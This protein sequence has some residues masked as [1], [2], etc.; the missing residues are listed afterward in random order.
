[1][2]ILDSLHRSTCVCAINFKVRECKKVAGW[3]QVSVTAALMR[4]CICVLCLDMSVSC[5]NWRLSPRACGKNNV[6]K[7]VGCYRSWMGVIVLDIIVVYWVIGSCVPSLLTE[8]LCHMSTLF[9][10]EADN[11]NRSMNILLPGIVS[12]LYTYTPSSQICVL[13]QYIAT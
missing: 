2:T 6:W 4:A 8:T 12:L 5:E 13:L 11:V 10:H 9:T 3:S 1:M 7:W